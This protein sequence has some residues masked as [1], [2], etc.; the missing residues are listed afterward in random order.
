MVALRRLPKQPPSPAASLAAACPRSNP[1]RF[2]WY[3]LL[4]TGGLLAL[5]FTSGALQAQSDGSD[6]ADLP[7]RRCRSCHG[8]IYESWRE[9]QHALGFATDEFQ[10]VWTRQR[11]SPECLTCHSPFVEAPARSQ[12]F[13]GVGCGSCHRTLDTERRKGD[14]FDYHGAMSTLRNPADCAACHGADHALT[15]T[16]WDSSAH[17]GMRTV[18]CFACHQPHSGSL[19]APTA[20]DLCASCHLQETPTANPHMHVDSGCTDCHPAPVHTDNIHMRGPEAEADCADCHMVTQPDRY[21]NFLANAGHTM[22][23]PLAACTNCHG[24]LHDLL[25]PSP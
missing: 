7:P 25:P 15:Y 22:A 11:E 8:D 20:L 12:S 2:V 6:Y 3:A 1:L 17:N 21:G 10:R 16:E 13:L 24:S 5:L 14:G 18:D 23:V 9:S 4:L 19:T